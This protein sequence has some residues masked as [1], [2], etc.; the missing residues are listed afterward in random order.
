MGWCLP[1]EFVGVGWEGLVNNK[2]QD[3]WINGLRN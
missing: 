3:G 1:V 2:N